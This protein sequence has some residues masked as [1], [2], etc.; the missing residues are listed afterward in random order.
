MDRHRDFAVAQGRQ[1][2]IP[3]AF[4]LG[5]DVVLHAERALKP[6]G[7]V[8]VRC[9]PIRSCCAI[10]LARRSHVRLAQLRQSLKLGFQRVGD[11]L[12]QARGPIRRYVRGASGVG[13]R[14][15]GRPR[16]GWGGCAL[17]RDLDLD[18]HDLQ[19]TL[20]SPCAEH[21]YDEEEA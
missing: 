16:L 10:L 8:V 12:A 6:R 13:L 21:A 17:M 4:D 1:I 7:D 11:R 20:R 14:Q 9:H 18:R 5:A 3:P 2:R 19:P 15:G